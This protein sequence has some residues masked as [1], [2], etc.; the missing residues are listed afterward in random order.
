MPRIDPSGKFQ[1]KTAFESALIW[2]FRITTQILQTMSP[3]CED[4]TENSF[5]L[6]LRC[7]HTLTVGLVVRGSYG[8]STSH[9]ANALGERQSANLINLVQKLSRT[10]TNGYDHW[11]NIPRDI[12]YRHV[13]TNE[14]IQKSRS[15]FLQ[16]LNRH[17]LQCY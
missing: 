13:N 4:S 9:F 3:I 1:R 10:A 14:A 11:T 12:G 2:Q 6:L 17:S 16:V 5:H 8:L 15:N 7:L